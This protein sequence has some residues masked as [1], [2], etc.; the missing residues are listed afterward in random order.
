MFTILLTIK[1]HIAQLL[2]P[3][4][5]VSYAKCV[6]YVI[7]YIKTTAIVAMLLDSNQL[8]C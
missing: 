7:N 1:F 8:S 2:T 5:G 3:W 6:I 4:C